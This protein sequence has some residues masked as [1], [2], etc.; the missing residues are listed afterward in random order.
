MNPFDEIALEEAIRMKE[1]GKV[2]EVIAVSIGPKDSEE[3]LR[4]AFAMGS[5]RAIHIDSGDAPVEPLH[6]AKLLEKVIEEEKPELVLLG[7]QAIDDDSNQTAQLL[8][9]RMDW[10]QATFAS[11]V[12]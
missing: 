10:P 5:D 12:F 2:G 6:V 3:T 4:V 7:K 9:G 1:A 8:S 11:E